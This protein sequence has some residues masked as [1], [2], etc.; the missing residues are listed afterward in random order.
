[1]ERQ[2]TISKDIK[3]RGHL[4]FDHTVKIEG[5]FQGTIESLGNL[6]IGPSGEVEADIKTKNLEHYGKLKGNIIAE[7]KIILRKNSL[8][9]GDLSCKDLEVESGSKFTGTCIMD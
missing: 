3:F 5:F 8:I 9:R 7:N 4:K 2:T 1:M 6:I